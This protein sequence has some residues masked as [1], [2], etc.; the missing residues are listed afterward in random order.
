MRQ[1]GR[2]GRIEAWAISAW[3]QPSLADQ[4]AAK[5]KC[6]KAANTHVSVI[7]QRVDYPWTKGAPSP[8]L[9]LLLSRIWSVGALVLSSAIHTERRSL[10]PV[11]RADACEL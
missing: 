1:S 11:G 8:T 5:T 2:R 3:A 6:I 4:E 9:S 7:S 10:H